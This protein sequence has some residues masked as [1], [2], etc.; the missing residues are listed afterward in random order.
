MQCE[1]SERCGRR[2]VFLGP[3]SHHVSQSLPINIIITINNISIYH[4]LLLILARLCILCR[5]YKN[6]ILNKIFSYHEYTSIYSIEKNIHMAFMWFKKKN[7][8]IPSLLY[9][10]YLKKKIFSYARIF[11]HCNQIYMNMKLMNFMRS[12]CSA[13]PAK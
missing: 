6:T 4:Y 8:C 12:D 2:V 5:I 3:S 10:I 11:T 7:H 9:Y 13:V 1:L